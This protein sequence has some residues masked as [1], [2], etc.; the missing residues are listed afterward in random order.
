MSLITLPRVVS[1]LN[2][3]MFYLSAICL[4]ILSETFNKDFVIII[5]F[6]IIIII[7]IIVIIISSSIYCSAFRYKL[8]TKPADT[9]QILDVDS[10]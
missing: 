10:K 6:I 9:D 3:L 7:I 2:T 1:I 5:I 8:L 4:S